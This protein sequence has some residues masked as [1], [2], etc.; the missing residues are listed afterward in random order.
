[1]SIETFIFSNLQAGKPC[2]VSNIDDAIFNVD[3]LQ[4]TSNFLEIN[5]HKAGLVKSINIK[6]KE[7]ESMRY[8]DVNKRGDEL[9][10]QQEELQKQQIKRENKDD[11]LLLMNFLQYALDNW[12]NVTDK[13][14]LPQKTSRVAVRTDT[15]NFSLN[16]GETQSVLSRTLAKTG[17]LLLI[18][19]SCFNLK[20]L[21]GVSH[22][23]ER[24]QLHG[25]NYWPEFLCTAKEF[26][27]RYVAEV[28]KALSQKIDEFYQK[29]TKRL[30]KQ[31]KE[32]KEMQSMLT[33]K[34][35]E[36]P[37]ANIGWIKLDN[38][39]Y[40]YQRRSIADNNGYYRMWHTG[41]KKFYGWFPPCTVGLNIV[42]KES[43]LKFTL[44]ERYNNIKILSPRPYKHPAVLIESDPHLCTRGFNKKGEWY[45]Y[46]GEKEQFEWNQRGKFLVK[47]K[48][49]INDAIRRI[50]TGLGHS[51]GKNAN[52]EKKAPTYSQIED[53]FPEYEDC[54]MPIGW[55]NNKLEWGIK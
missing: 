24:V 40:L 32:K 6:E 34:Q 45:T 41:S 27:I 13:E 21:P 49:S 22:I 31:E 30:E 36:N 46:P 5:G 28:E 16:A 1:M 43:K 4:A 3:P 19:D 37:N 15:D 44:S 17:P 9:R 29:E 55:A 26:N 54:K 50:E 42:A 8:E 14:I 51:Q 7:E 23:G 35:K 53:K 12:I 10:R 38:S 48:M 33:T 39:Y 47:I 52:V 20:E 2:I 18:C 25:K 11:H